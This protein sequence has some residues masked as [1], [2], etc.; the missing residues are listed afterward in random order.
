[1]IDDAQ[2]NND[3]SRDYTMPPAAPMMNSQPSILGQ[4]PPS[5]VPQYNA[6]AQYMPGP[7]GYAPPQSTGG[8]GPGAPAGPQSMPMQQHPQQQQQQMQMHNHPY[9][10]QQGMPS[11]M[12]PGPTHYNGQN[13]YPQGGPPPRY[14]L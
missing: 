1:M 5:A 12:G 9:M 13:G 11:E 8:W 2:V 10:P 7:E 3:R 4:Q 6:T 14:H